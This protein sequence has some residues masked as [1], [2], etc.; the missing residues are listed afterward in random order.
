MGRTPEADS[1]RHSDPAYAVFVSAYATLSSRRQYDGRAGCSMRFWKGTGRIVG[2]LSSLSR[3]D[4]TYRRSC[5]GILSWQVRMAFGSRL[6]WRAC[7]PG[8][9]DAL[10]RDTAVFAEQ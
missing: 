1:Q 3:S 10:Q 2:T 7:L 8:P 5:T 4:T 6:R 9:A